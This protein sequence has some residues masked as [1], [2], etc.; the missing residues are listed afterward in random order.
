MRV[1]IGYDEREA[2][3]AEVAAKTLRQVTV[4]AIEPEFLCAPKLSDQGLLYRIGDHRG[5]QDYD[6]VS[7]AP[8]ST[9]FAVS[10]FLTPIL[11]Q[12]GYA[13]FVDCDMVFEVDPRAML[14][15]VK[16]EHAVSVVKHDHRPTEQWKM[17]NQQ[18]T[19][20]PRKNWSSV[21]IFNCEHP[22]NRRLSVRD[23]NERPGRDLHAFYW[24][25]DNEIGELHPRFNWLVDVQPRPDNL[26]I[27]HMTLGGPWLSGW[28]GGSFD[29]E[30]LA[31]R[32]S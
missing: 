28:Q 19:T 21:M 7:N 17:V 32:D 4:G 15:E 11:C 12:T 27:A 23:V 13:L 3:A 30:W 31:A 2:E 16:A 10:R 9:R 24:L 29:A 18:Q 8:K 25:H 14:A 5:G 20:Y 1:F 22:A 6:F 26:V